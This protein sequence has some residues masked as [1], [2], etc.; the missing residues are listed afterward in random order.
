MPPTDPA[1]CSEDACQGPLAPAP[2]LNNPSS[3]SFSGAGNVSEP[4]P[5]PRCAKGK[6]RR[7]GRCVKQR[8]RIKHRHHKRA[9]HVKEGR[10]K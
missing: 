8:K 1:H 2:V 7:H 6:V 9:A 5:K 4:T 10:G 3:S